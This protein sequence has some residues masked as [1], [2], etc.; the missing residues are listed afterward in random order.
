MSSVLTS[1]AQV[2]R[3][4]DPSINQRRT[5]RV[6]VDLVSHIAAQGRTYGARVI[7]ISELG[8]MC[9]TDAGV[10]IGERISIWLPVLKDIQADVRWAEDGRVGVEFCE[11]IDPPLYEAMLSLIPPRRT[12]W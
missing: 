11:R 8:L 1:L 3:S 7:N 6:L 12:A 10:A 2:A 4:R 9:R 5:P